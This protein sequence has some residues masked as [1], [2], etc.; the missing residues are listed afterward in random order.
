M[1]L[2]KELFMAFFDDVK[3]IL[4]DAKQRTEN[5]A[6]GYATTGKELL[7][8][9][10]K[11]AGYRRANESEIAND[12]TKAYYE[13]PT[14]AVAWLF[15]VRDV[16]GGLGER[17]LFRVA[18]KELANI[19]EQVFIDLL[20]L[21]AEY[22]R[23]DDI[24]ELLGLSDETDTAIL[25]VVIEQFNL[26]FYHMNFNEPISLLAKWL[27]TENCSNYKRKAKARLVIN[28]LDITPSAYRKAVSKMRKHLDVVEVKVSNNDWELIDYNTVPSCANLKYMNAFMRHDET[29]RTNYLESLK[30]GD[31]DIKINAGVLYPHDI[32]HK[33]MYSSWGR[34]V[35]DY[36]ETIEQLW[37]NLP[38]MVKE[39]SNTL[40]VA[41]GSGSMTVTVGESGVTALEVA[42]ALAI[43]FA[44]HNHGAFANKYITFSKRP[45]LVD[46]SNATTLRDKLKIALNHSEVANTNIEAT[47]DLILQTAIKNNYEQSDMPENIVIISDMEFDYAVD[48]RMDVTLFE[49]LTER[50]ERAGYKMPRLVFWNVNSRTNTIPVKQNDL[51]VAL[52]SGFSVNLCNMVLSGE[53]DPYIALVKEIIKERYY[54][55]IEVAKKHLTN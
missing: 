18:M 29:R 32:V 26:D 33:Y 15:Y 30:R 14:L 36:D 21:V 12:F 47:F 10:F 5:G 19:N 20:P 48:G 31:K 45:Q 22:G 50:F 51:G 25:K 40:V 38:D 11:V 35:K 23:W 54:P 7:D 24:F 9:N 49:N 16:R 27:P 39:E 6:L 28:A 53:T 4:D 44:E 42:N 13:D 41:D 55:V 34:S 2:G 17:R 3:E 52:I 37:K 46:F 8:M 43:Y 1:R